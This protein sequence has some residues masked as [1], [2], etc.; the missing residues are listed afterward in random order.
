MPL[1]EKIYLEHPE[2]C[3][4]CYSCV[5]TCSLELFNIVSATRTAISLKP[6][7]LGDPFTV[8]FCT[9]CDKPSC[10][11]ACEALQQ[12]KEGK[13][14]L[15]DPSKCDKCETFDCAK[16]CVTGALLIDPETNKPILCTQCAKCA[17][18]CPHEVI[19]FKETKQ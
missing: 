18:I 16:A 4:G 7:S 19:K 6:C 13:L 8:I 12:D 1:R 17:E 5:F 2:R 14:K 15:I 10:V 3:L 9:G 11:K